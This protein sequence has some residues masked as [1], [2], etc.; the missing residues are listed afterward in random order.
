[1]EPPSKRFKGLDKAEQSIF[2]PC[3]G[4]DCYDFGSEPRTYRAGPGTSQRIHSV[5]NLLLS[6][7]LDTPAKTQNCGSG[8]GSSLCRHDRD[9]PSRE[10]Q[11]SY[12][13]TY[14]RL[15]LAVDE[16]V[17]DPDEGAI[18]APY[19]V[20]K[21]VR[22]AKAAS[23][24]SGLPRVIVVKPQKV[25]SKEHQNQTIQDTWPKGKSRSS[26]TPELD[27]GAR[28][29][30]SS[31]RS[32]D[33][34][35]QKLFPI[36][37][38]K[39]QWKTLHMIRHGESEYNAATSFGTAFEDPIIFDPQLTAKG[40]RQAL[41]L[42]EE[43]KRLALPDG[44]LFVTSPLTRA[45]ETLLLAKPC[46]QCPRECAKHLLV[47]SELAEQLITTGDVGLPAS[48]IRRR[49]P[50]LEEAIK[51][52][53]ER[54]WYKE[55]VNDATEKRLTNTETKKELMTR[56]EALRRW[57][58]ARPEKIIVAVGHSVCFGALAG[59]SR[60]RNCEVRTIKI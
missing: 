58:L 59:G 25:P 1:M 37:R 26:L 20:C 50:Q 10:F 53:P 19:D 32:P 40:R 54:W 22:E 38:P 23:S 46:F 31:G 42:R 24:N 51:D 6:Q 36:F 39:T 14:S 34:G 11:I 52:L 55:S 17:Q 47:R 35:P 56:V 8:P 41:R 33:A 43:L 12:S 5:G 4:F 44:V 3:P 13:Q 48:Q 30:E 57:L 7:S 21:A 28:R 29:R 9:S 49:F 2:S 45:I 27:G 16:Q 60:L 15:S 18:D